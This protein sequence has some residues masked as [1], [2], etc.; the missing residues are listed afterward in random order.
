MPAYAPPGHP[1]AIVTWSEENA[2]VAPWRAS[3]CLRWT[4]GRPRMVA[5][6]SGTLQAG[7]L[8]EL[9]V[10]YGA[11]SQYKSIRFWS[12]LHQA[13]EELVTS[14]GFVDGPEAHYSAPDLT[15]AD[16]VSGRS[17]YYYEIDRTGRTIHRLTVQRRTQ[18]TVE[19]ATDN[20]TPIHYSMFLVFEAQALQTS[21]FIHR[22]GPREWGYYQTIGAGEGAGFVAVRSPSPYVNRL[23]ALYR[24]MAGIP[25]DSLPPAAPN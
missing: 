21:T 15:E 24:Y 14:A 19:L 9:L 13:W 17:L 20:V 4:A 11:L 22:L 23:T 10:R 7:S 8:D 12:T 2:N 18:D 6:L 5:A 25:T 3:P 16:Y 1:P